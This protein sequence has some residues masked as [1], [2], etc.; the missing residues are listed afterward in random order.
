M[1]KLL[2]KSGNQPAGTFEGHTR[3]V[4]L[5]GLQ[6]LATAHSS[7]QAMGLPS[8][9]LQRLTNIS[10]LAFF[11][12]DFGKAGSD[13]QAEL[14]HHVRQR[15]RHEALSVWMVLHLPPLRAWL[16]EAVSSE[17]DLAI[18]LSAAGGHHTK[19]NK[20]QTNDGLPLQVFSGHPDFASLLYFGASYLGL[21]P[22]PPLSNVSV[23]MKTR[24]GLEGDIKE[25]REWIDDT[26]K[27]KD[28]AL[29]A[30][31]KLL[32][33]VSDVCGSALPRAR[34]DE[35]WLQKVLSRPCDL[36]GVV[37]RIL[38]NPPRAFQLSVRDSV[39]PVTLVKAGTGNGKT[40]AAYLWAHSRG[41]SVIFCYPT[42]GTATEGYR[43]DINGTG[44]S[45]YLE[46]S[47]V[48]ADENEFDLH[49][50]IQDEEEIE[51]IRTISMYA[52]SAVVCTVD[53]LLGVTCNLNKGRW[54]WPLTA[55]SSIVF[56]EI[57]AYDS[58]MFGALLGFIRHFPGIPLLLMTAS[59]P[60][61]REA[62]LQAAVFSVHGV[63]MEVIGGDAALEKHKRYFRSFD[64]PEVAI[65]KAV[66]SGG[67][68]LV[69]KNTVGACVEAYLSYKGPGRKLI[70]HSRFRYED[71]LKHH[72]EVV[73]G[74]GA[75]E[76]G[77]VV[78]FTTQVAEMSLNISADL[79]VTDIAPV[80]S[81]IQRLGRLNR[82]GFTPACPFVVCGTGQPLPYSTASLA[83]G[84]AWLKRLQGAISQVD[85][86]SAVIDG[87]QEFW[88]ARCPLL[89]AHPSSTIPVP[90][91]KTEL[92]SV[93]VLLEK[94]AAVVRAHTARHE[95]GLAAAARIKGAIPMVRT[96]RI[97]PLI[98]L[99]PKE[100][101]LPVVTPAELSYSTEI[102]A[103][104]A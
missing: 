61:S 73:S 46:H 28:K 57:H 34:K 44:T 101:Y 36:D 74:L 11:I 53:T 86:Q 95:W 71:R 80:S 99:L 10:K 98:E 20:P 48:T 77:A 45:S 24:G 62:A 69:V 40:S 59:L 39:S 94:D 64:P 49:Q 96:D 43:V 12:H 25:D 70:Y 26:I 8:E 37:G 76:A 82:F 85:L 65:L 17:V 103:E 15:V 67:K 42:T 81:L 23:D 84:W 6:I 90:F 16:L 29:V 21:P 88:L 3:A 87:E 33:T 4:C 50:G 52:A 97:S 100:G 54:L 22:P 91:R 19:T 79:L 60:A 63:Q 58:D 27:A 55:R 1:E 102:G 72:R 104:W 66:T 30:A 93:N 83:E 89:D 13:F 41:K 7:L 78:V 38:Q 56:D 5:H 14:A 2:A 68:V 92:P 32:V 51:Q 18:A 47:R 9:S 75:Q 31:V 35:A